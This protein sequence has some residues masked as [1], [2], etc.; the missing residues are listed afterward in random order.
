MKK[1]V[2]N[3]PVGYGTTVYVFCDKSG[4]DSDETEII[5]DFSKSSFSKIFVLADPGLLHIKSFGSIEQTEV[6]DALRAVLKILES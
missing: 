1:I 2:F 4:S 5:L 6:C 3:E